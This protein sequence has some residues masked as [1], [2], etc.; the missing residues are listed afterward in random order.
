[1]ASN[2]FGISFY[3]SFLTYLFLNRSVVLTQLLLK[4]TYVNNNGRSDWRKIWTE[5]SAWVTKNNTNAQ[6]RHKHFRV[7]QPKWGKTFYVSQITNQT[8]TPI[9]Y[10]INMTTTWKTNLDTRFSFRRT[11]IQ[12]ESPCSDEKTN[13]NQTQIYVGHTNKVSLLIFIENKRCHRPLITPPP[14]PP[15]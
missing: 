8:F 12:R 14:P 10:R 9:G 2:F 1:M 5:I 7:Q 3:L 6:W 11:T 4:K 15:L 13:F